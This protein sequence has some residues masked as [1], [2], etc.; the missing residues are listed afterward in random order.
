L[1]ANSEHAAVSN[2]QKSPR[3]QEQLEPSVFHRIGIRGE[4]KGNPAR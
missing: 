1:A 2:Q 4:M 3:E